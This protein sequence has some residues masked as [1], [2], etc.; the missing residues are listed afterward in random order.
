MSVIESSS[1]QVAVPARRNVH[2]DPRYAVLWKKRM[3]TDQ[4]DRV[5]SIGVGII[6]LTLLCAI[7]VIF[8]ERERAIE[9]WR[10][11]AEAESR[12]LAAHA[13]QTL[14]AADLVLRSV[15]D[16]ASEER[17]SNVGEMRSL[18]G[19]REYHDLLRER[20]KGVVQ[21]SV[22]SIVDRN[23]D[24]VNFTRTYPPLSNTGAQIN[25]AERDYFQQHLN[26]D[27]LDLFLSEPVK[28]K[29]TGSWTFYL[30]RK[31]RSVSGE[32]LG[33]VLVGIECQYFVEFFNAVA[34]PG[35]QYSI[36]LSN[37]TNL[38]RFP[39]YEQ[40]SGQPGQNLLAS[41]VFKTITS[42]ASSAVVAANS[43]S[44]MNSS[45]GEMRIVAPS[46]VS[47]Y[48]LVV[49]V[50]LSE[51]L[52]LA[53]WRRF[54]YTTIAIALCL[55]ALLLV[56]IMAIRSLQKKNMASIKLIESARKRAEQESIY[57]GHFLA[58]MS[59]EIRT[60]LNAITGLTDLLAKHHLPKKSSELV[61]VVRNSA[62]HLATIV[63]DVLDF[64]ALEEVKITLREENVSL[65]RML[66]DLSGIAH[67]LPGTSLL[68]LKF[69]MADDVPEFIVTD[70]SRV[71]QVL[72]NLLSNAIKFT[73]SGSVA[74]EVGMASSGGDDIQLE[75]S[76][77]D[78]GSGVLMS[79]SEQLFEP[80][81]RGSKDPLSPD[82][83]TGLGL[84]ISRR[85]ARRMGGD[86]VLVY[87]SKS[88]SMFRFTLS[89][90]RGSRLAEVPEPVGELSYA[91][92]ILVAED[93]VAGQMV[94][95]GMLESMG[96]EVRLVSNG[97]EAVDAFE[98]DDFDVIFM[99]I[100][101]PVLDG[102]H[103]ARLIRQ[104]GRRG[105]SVPIVALTAYTQISEQ[106]GELSGAITMC[107]P[108]PIQERSLCS[109]L[110]R[111]QSI[112]SE[113]RSIGYAFDCLPAV[114]VDEVKLKEMGEALGADGTTA[115]VKAFIRDLNETASKLKIQMNAGDSVG[116]ARLA[117]RMK[118]LFA[119]FGAIEPARLA[120]EIEAG[121]SG[122]T[123][124]AVAQLLDYVPLA[125]E[126]VQRATGMASASR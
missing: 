72:L 44:V 53:A 88:G 1:N 99:D 52:I 27:S 12:M 57:K 43:A 109:A 124:E 47:A 79:Q 122:K 68:N 38:A 98:S 33:L 34:S 92:R 6:M 121:K 65:R 69:V 70:R 9:F 8:I 24:M 77:S 78:T 18:L 107:I 54:S 120:A 61:M 45:P 36:F 102:Y 15:I 95:R 114:N 10:N 31:I 97:R 55:S 110:D 63:S 14:A 118:G 93:T 50:R 23:G 3:R 40:P 86:L 84:A 91:M 58:N 42:G 106:D 20:Q 74:L 11:S 126:A 94:M 111:L 112:I 125:I 49:N 64:S 32:M 104:T 30:A 41:P 80:F 4:S 83:G 28:N 82:Q 76:V 13:Q 113:R 35:K 37:G 66:D 117:H 39:G 108:K 105:L 96:H 51:E 62:D 29:G 25:L 67:G 90:R 87:S 75:F 19:T 101:M 5:V 73:K 85:I 48:P 71:M 89:V 21:V 17:V 2:P 56:L 60:P 116:V 26:N 46:R 123:G 103:A 115:A 59:H 7:S 119:Q 22:A 16:K 100:Q 81:A